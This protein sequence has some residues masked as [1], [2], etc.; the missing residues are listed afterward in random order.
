MHRDLRAANNNI[1]AEQMMTF[2][3]AVTSLPSLWDIEEWHSKI[4]PV[5]SELE[6][7]KSSSL[8]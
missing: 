7:F 5:L 4:Y 8:C 1:D 2:S 6:V 3:I